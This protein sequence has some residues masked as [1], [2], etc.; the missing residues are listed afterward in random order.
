MTLPEVTKIR[1]L[2]KLNGYSEMYLKQSGNRIPKLLSSGLRLHQLYRGG[3][4]GR[5]DF[6][7][8][9]ENGQP[10]DDLFRSDKLH[11]TEKGYAV[12]TEIIRKELNKIVSPPKL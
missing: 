4:Y 6:A 5:T 11:L 1:V 9:N 2:R 12:W 10:R 8:L 7:F 3:K